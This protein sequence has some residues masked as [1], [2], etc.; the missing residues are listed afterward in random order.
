[1]EEAFQS[2]IK[3]GILAKENL[4]GVRFNIKDI[5]LDNDPM[6]RGSGEIIPTARRAY[7]ACELTANPRFQEPIYFCDIYTPK[8]FVRD[9]YQ[10]LMQRKSIILAQ[11]I[12]QGA[13]MVDINVYLPAVE[14][15]GLNEQL[16]VISTGKIISQL[17]F[18]HWELI[19]DDPFDAISKSYEIMMN[20][21]KRKGLKLELPK[22]EDYIDKD[23]FHIL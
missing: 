16:N 5:I 4:R 19:N 15:F 18:D 6:H 14:S 10:C 17:Y 7:Y 1:M 8:D 2:V 13:D 12:K 22:I 9:V 21:R 3:E 23:E 11:K 20:I